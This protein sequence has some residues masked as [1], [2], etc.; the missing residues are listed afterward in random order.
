MKSKTTF[1][2][3]NSYNQTKELYKAGITQIKV[4]KPSSDECSISLRRERNVIAALHSRC[5]AERF[6]FLTSYFDLP[7]I[8]ELPVEVLKCFSK[9]PT[10]YK[11]KNIPENISYNM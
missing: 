1:V 2:L 3:I 8:V 10:T 4:V 5:G 9:K 7:V 6:N 11:E